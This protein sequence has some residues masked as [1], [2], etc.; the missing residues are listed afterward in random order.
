MRFSRNFSQ[1]T[2]REAF[3]VVF[4]SVVRENA[5]GSSSLE[6]WPS[7]RP[8]GSS[9]R[10]RASPGVL[11]GQ[12]RVVIQLAPDLFD[13]LEARKL[14]QADGLLQLGRHHQLLGQA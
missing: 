7:T 14:Q 2:S 11:V 4:A 6:G 1:S 8:R 5:S 3:S 10:L 12:H 9:P 13:Q